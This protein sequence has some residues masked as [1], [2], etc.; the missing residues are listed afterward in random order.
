MQAAVPAASKARPGRRPCMHLSADTPVWRQGAAPCGN[1]LLVRQGILRLER[2]TTAGERRIV[3][4]AGRGML[5][6]LEGWLG[7]AH[8]DDLVS[9][10]P[11]Q[12]VAL[13]C[14]DVDQALRRQQAGYTR[15]LPHWHQGLSEAQ[16]WS[17]ELLRGSARQRTLL[18]VQRLLLLG[19]GQ[20]SHPVVWPPRRGDMVAMLGLTDKSV[21]RQ[22]SRLRRDGLICLLDTRSVQV[23]RQRLAQALAAA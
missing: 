9:C 20:G 8:A 4:L 22:I 23:N 7:Q 13:C 3:G 11:V 10:T 15:L 19:A 5:L 14:R 21:S 17:A 18:L 6:G 16:A 2:V 12:L 1:V